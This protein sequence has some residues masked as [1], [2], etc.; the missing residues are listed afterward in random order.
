MARKIHW[1]TK[2]EKRLERERRR[3]QKRKRIREHREYFEL[4]KKLR[5]LPERPQDAYGR[6]VPERLKEI[7]QGRQIL[8]DFALRLDFL[9]GEI[10]QIQKKPYGIDHNIPEITNALESARVK[11][12]QATP[13]EPCDCHGWNNNCQKCQN[14]RWVSTLS[15]MKKRPPRS[16]G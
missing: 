9:R 2:W 12:V 13:L 11:I 3:E 14:Y 6:N 5:E 4:A 10:V 1:K 15:L 8:R 16:R 7:F